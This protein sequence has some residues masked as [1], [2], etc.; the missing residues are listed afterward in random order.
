MQLYWGPRGGWGNFTSVPLWAGFKGRLL[1]RLGRVGGLVLSVTL[2]YTTAGF[3]T[4][5][6][7]PT[8]LI[9]SNGT[10]LRTGGC[11]RTCAGFDACLA[12]AGGRSSM[13]TCGYNIYTSGVGGPTRTLGC[14]SVTMRGGCGLTGTCVNGTNTL[15]S[16]GGGSRCITALGRKLRTGPNGGALA[17]L[18]TACCMGR[19]VVTRGTGGVSTTRR[20]FGRT[21]TVRTSGM[22]TLGDLNSLCCDGN[23]GAVG[24][25]MRG[26][27]I[28]FGRTGRCLSGLVPLLSTSGPTRGGVVSG[29][30]AVLGFVSDRLGWGALLCGGRTSV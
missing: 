25:S 28:R 2:Y 30:G 4:R 21:V 26:T 7:S 15:G 3:F 11:R 1:G 9:G 22:G 20:T 14:F 8:R 24:A 6:T 23:T 29:T 10:T 18:C 16:L 19:N 5:G 27:G 17:G 13:V 12:R